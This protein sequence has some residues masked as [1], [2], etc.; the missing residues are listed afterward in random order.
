[1]D[2]AGQ[3]RAALQ[4]LA[5]VVEVVAAAGELG[6]PSGPMYAALMSKMSLPQYEQLMGMLVNVGALTCSGHCYHVTAKGRAL[7]RSAG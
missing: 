6:A 1:M 5:A 7:V 2:N 3:D 4:I